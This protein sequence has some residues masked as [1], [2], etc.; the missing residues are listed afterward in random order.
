MSA[1]LV[2]GTNIW[3][4]STD[5]LVLFNGKKF[6]HYNIEDGL[7]HQWIR[8]IKKGPKEIFGLELGVE[9]LFLT[10]LDLKS[11]GKAWANE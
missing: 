11:L 3:L 4:G 1:I 8:S 6:R 2:E 9:F 7:I 10:G 5:G